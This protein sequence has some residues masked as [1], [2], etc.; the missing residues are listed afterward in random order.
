MTAGSE[1]RYVVYDPID[2]DY[3]TATPIIGLFIRWTEVKRL[4]RRFTA[5]EAVAEVLAARD[6]YRHLQERFVVVE[7]PE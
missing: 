2:R 5:T 6:K 7:V 4:A 1:R 3:A